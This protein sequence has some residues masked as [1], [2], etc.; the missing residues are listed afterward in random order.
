MT[1][2]AAA[3]G[4]V[5]ISFSAILFALSETSPITGTFYRAAYALPVL[6]M[7]WL[8]RRGADTRPMSR[9]WMAVGAGLS[10]GADVFTWHN[11]IEF[12]GAGLATLIANT[13]VIFVALGAWVILGER[14]R[15]TTLLTVPVILF[16]VALVSG[17]GQGSAFGEDP[18]G[19]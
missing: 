5:T 1:L 3:A 8:V 14:P 17:V 13:Q 9:R 12:I 18:A 4:A 6:V 19:G 15:R 16:G 10:L 7:L 2:L 11:S